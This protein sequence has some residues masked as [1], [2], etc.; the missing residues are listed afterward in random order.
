MIRIRGKK[1]TNRTGQMNIDPDAVEEM[2]LKIIRP[3]SFSKDKKHM[4]TTANMRRTT[5]QF[6]WI[7]VYLL[8]VL[9]MAKVF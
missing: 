6:I 5:P 8:Y 4:T 7:R 2:V 1:S 3:Y 9:C